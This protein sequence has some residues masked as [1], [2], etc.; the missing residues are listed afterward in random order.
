MI[1]EESFARAT[2]GLYT[3]YGLELYNNYLANRKDQLARERVVEAL[4]F[5]TVQEYAKSA[6]ETHR[7][8]ADEIEAMLIEANAQANNGD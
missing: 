8:K 1:N 5:T 4:K 7:R 2:W 3:R 6:I